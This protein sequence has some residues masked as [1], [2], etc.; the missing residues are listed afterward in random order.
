MINHFIHILDI[1]KQ[2]L[3]NDFAAA[4]LNTINAV[5]ED[6]CKFMH[7]A[8]KSLID[9]VPFYVYKILNNVRKL[10]SYL[11]VD[12]LIS[13]HLK[14]SVTRTFRKLTVAVNVKTPM[15]IL[16]VLKLKFRLIIDLILLMIQTIRKPTFLGVRPRGW[17]V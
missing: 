2:D 10:Q 3:E 16:N 8:S 13:P 14:L 4:R 17:V 9:F 7:C 15:L 5:D 12:L 6:L 1:T 11:W